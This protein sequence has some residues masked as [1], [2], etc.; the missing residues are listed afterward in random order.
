MM[1]LITVVI[2]I[3]LSALV[4][5]AVIYYGGKAYSNASSSA[6]VAALMTQGTQIKAASALYMSNND[7]TAPTS[8]TQLVSADLLQSSPPNW[9]ITTSGEPAVYIS[10][11]GTNVCQKFNEKYDGYAPNAPVP[12]CSSTTSSQPVCC[13]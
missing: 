6:Q 7:G 4:G 2:A 11:I 5:I 8:V 13:D 9:S 1:T 3:I 10:V 12:S